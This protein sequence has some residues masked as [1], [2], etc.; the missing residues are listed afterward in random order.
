MMP[1]S[2]QTVETFRGVVYPWHCD[3]MG[4]M[5][6]QFYSGLF[7]G[8]TFH[9]L[10]LLC[11]NTELKLAGHGWADVRQLIEYKQETVCGDLLVVRSTLTR[12]GNKSIEYRHD[13]VNVETDIV[14]ATSEQVT[15][16]FDLVARKAVLLTDVIRSRAMA[17]VS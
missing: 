15:V 17:D 1:L 16:L 12:L 3:A 5:N 6:T 11:S 2:L 9:F 14:H 8:A 7:D 4:H 10:A 13:L